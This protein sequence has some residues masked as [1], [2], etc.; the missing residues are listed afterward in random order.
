MD[1]DRQATIR[2]LISSARALLAPDIGE[3]EG[4]PE[5]GAISPPERFTDPSEG[6]A[7]GR[8]VNLIREHSV[9]DA[10]LIGRTP[11]PETGPDRDGPGDST[12]AV[13]SANSPSG[14]A[15]AKSGPADKATGETSELLEIQDRYRVWVKSRS[16]IPDS[17]IPHHSEQGN[18]SGAHYYYDISFGTS[19][20][21]DI[22][23][24][25]VEPDQVTE[26]NASKD[27]SRYPDRDD[28]SAIEVPDV[29]MQTVRHVEAAV[30]NER[31][32]FGSELYS[33]NPTVFKSVRSPVTLLY[34]YKSF[35]DGGRRYSDY[36]TAIENE[37]DR[38]RVDRLEK[39][40]KVRRFVG[41]SGRA[42]E[43]VT[44]EKGDRGGL[45]FDR[46]DGE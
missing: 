35:H 31:P 12:D 36:L 3:R 25:G 30:E 43:T 19:T 37:L 8:L 16:A 5:T 2:S 21:I 17:R 44:I 22:G 10:E 13:A 11:T 45:Y 6:E 33:A 42:S 38:R 32:A 40:P 15:K 24:H 39:V 26:K 7:M 46:S 18:G 28:L 34:L 4:D 29:D 23:K 9:F 14:Q 1:D 41:D 20:T 27:R